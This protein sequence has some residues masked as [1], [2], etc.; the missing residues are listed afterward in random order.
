VKRFSKRHASYEETMIGIWY[1]E[2]YLGVVD[3]EHTFISS[4]TRC[5]SAERH[6]LQSM[7]C[8]PCGACHSTRA[9]RDV[10]AGAQRDCSGRSPRERLCIFRKIPVDV[11]QRPGF[12]DVM[13]YEYGPLT[14]LE[15][16]ILLPKIEGKEGHV[17]RQRIQQIEALAMKKLRGKSTV[18]KM[19][20]ESMS[21]PLNVWDEMEST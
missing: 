17:T 20:N 7:L 18:E 6:T 19:R 10:G 4:C 16:A 12:I 21:K 9:L 14:Q 3:N 13:L 2:E 11:C 1:V 15:I 8:T 5:N